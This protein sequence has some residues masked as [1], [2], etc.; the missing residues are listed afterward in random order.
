MWRNAEVNDLFEWM[1]QFN[2]SKTKSQ[3]QVGFY[4]LD[5]YN[6]NEPSVK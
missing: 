1:R 4:G 3:Q 2:E 6:M 5:L